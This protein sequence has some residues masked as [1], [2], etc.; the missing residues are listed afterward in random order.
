M[1]AMSPAQRAELESRA[2][3]LVRRGDMAEALSLLG[4]LAAAFPEDAALAQR[5]SHLS[6]ALQP[7]ELLNPRARTSEPEPGFRPA[8]P[9]QEGE[10]LFALGDCAGAMAAYRRALKERPDSELVRERLEELFRLAQ[11]AP[12]HSTTDRALP[13]DPAERL[14]AL[15]DRIAARR[16]L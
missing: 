3:K 5:I 8:T 4:T 9:E 11:A 7:S 16:R 6:D 14:G 15:L 12:R 13:S 2:E 1:A 10:R